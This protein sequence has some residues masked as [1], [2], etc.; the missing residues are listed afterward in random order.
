MS[1]RDVGSVTVESN[2]NRRVSVQRDTGGKR[3]NC[4]K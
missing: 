4:V 3:V 2:R 1:G